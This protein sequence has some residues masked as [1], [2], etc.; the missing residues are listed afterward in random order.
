MNETTTTLARN[1]KPG[2][3]YREWTSKSGVALDRRVL[4]VE[5]G[6]MYVKVLTEVEGQTG[7]KPLRVAFPL[8]GPVELV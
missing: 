1:L 8:N 2:D 4:S 5:V 3:V 7:R 6:L